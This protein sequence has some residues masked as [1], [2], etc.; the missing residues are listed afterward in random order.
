MLNVAS[1]ILI[2]VFYSNDSYGVSCC[3]QEGI[4]G[5]ILEIIIATSSYLCHICTYI[6][7]SEIDDLRDNDC[8]VD[9]GGIVIPPRL[10]KTSVR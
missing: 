6:S 10:E 9:H 5:W 3:K 8:T 7:G 4:V 2:R 1:L